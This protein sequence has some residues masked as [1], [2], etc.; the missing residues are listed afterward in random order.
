MREGAR[1]WLLVGISGVLLGLCGAGS[2]TAE[3]IDQSAIIA[4]QHR[5]PQVN[6][7]WQAG[8]CFADSPATECSVDTPSLFFEQ[9]AGH[10]QIGFTQFIVKHTSTVVGPVTLEE[11][12]GDIKT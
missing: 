5:P 1:I 2:A 7:G 4:P 9:A 6:D 11:P 3:T 10:P 8:T 12:V